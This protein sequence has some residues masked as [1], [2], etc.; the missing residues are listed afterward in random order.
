MTKLATDPSGRQRWFVDE[1]IVW[2]L[3]LIDV[4]VAERTGEA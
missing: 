4:G 1:Q 2:H 3:V